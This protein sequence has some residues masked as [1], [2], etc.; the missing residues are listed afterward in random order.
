MTYKIAFA[1][2]ESVEIVAQFEMGLIT[3]TEMYQKQI[4]MASRAGLMG[5][6]ELAALA[7]SIFVYGVATGKY[8]S[9][10]SENCKYC[11]D[12]ASLRDAIVAWEEY[13]PGSAWSRIEHTVDSFVYALDP[14][15]IRKA[16]RIKMDSGET[17]TMYMPCDASGNLISQ[18]PEPEP[19]VEYCKHDRDYADC[20]ECSHAAY[21]EWVKQE[22]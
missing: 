7:S 1:C 11:D 3:E 17:R 10:G 22:N 6:E 12:F 21:Q 16:Q 18:I 9:D 19:D 2:P 20:H 14:C 13:S 5:T 4:D 15:K 8:E